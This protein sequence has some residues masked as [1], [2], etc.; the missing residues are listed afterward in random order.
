M[1]ALVLALFAA[2]LPWQADAPVKPERFTAIMNAG[3]MTPRPTAV[4]LVIDRWGTR[5]DRDRL[6]AALQGGGQAALAVALH[7]ESAGGYIYTQGHERLVAG[8]VQQDALPD[9]GRRILFLCERR[10]GEWELA[11]DTGRTAFLFR[12]VELTLDAQNRG[13]G[14]VYHTAKAD[15]G[16]DGVRLVEELSGQPTALLSVRK[17]R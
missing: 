17:T 16:R 3:P 10:T 15:V 7:K 9:G 6:A 2:S 12:I 4:D 14:T 8:Y 1:R 13:T 5:A 11:N